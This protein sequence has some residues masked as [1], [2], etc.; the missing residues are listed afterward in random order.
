MAAGGAKHNATDPARNEEKMRN[1][2]RIEVAENARER[3]SL[4]NLMN[5]VLIKEFGLDTKKLRRMTTFEHKGHYNFTFAKEEM[6]TAMLNDLTTKSEKLSGCKIIP[7][8]SPAEY[9]VYVFMFNPD[10]PPWDIDKFLQRYCSSVKG[11]AEQKN[12]WGVWNGNR[13]FTVTLRQD[14]NGIGGLMHLPGTFSIGPHR[15]FL[16]YQGQPSWCKN[17]HKFGHR[18]DNCANF[19]CRNCGSIQHKTQECTEPKSCNLCGKK[20][21][22]YRSCPQRQTSYAAAAGLRTWPKG[23]SVIMPQKLAPPKQDRSPQMEDE[24]VHDSEIVEAA[25]D[26]EVLQEVEDLE[27]RHEIQKIAEEIWEAE[28]QDREQEERM[29]APEHK[30]AASSP[31]FS[32]SRQQSSKTQ[33]QESHNNL[34]EDLPTHTAQIHRPATVTSVTPEDDP[35]EV[36]EQRAGNTTAASDSDLVPPT[37]QPGEN[38]HKAAIPEKAGTTICKLREIREKSSAKLPAKQNNGKEESGRQKANRREPPTKMQEDPLEISSE[39]D[40][41]PDS[42][43]TTISHPDAAER[44]EKIKKKGSKLKKDSAKAPKNAKEGK[45]QGPRGK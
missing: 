34:G 11:G 22:V 33:A 2:L 25:Q 14:E 27:T 23:E 8:A 10:V 19:S 9:T 18:K 15:G 36:D 45:R 17:C 4:K 21:H 29:K 44:W 38:G 32:A 30:L 35:E 40:P 16:N 24:D 31:P 28:R 13:K 43:D 5:E 26:A 7:L 20:G 41:E 3:M 6:Y 1:S 42:D 39:E 37:P 12:E